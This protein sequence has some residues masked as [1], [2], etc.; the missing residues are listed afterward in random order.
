MPPFDYTAWSG[1]AAVSKNVAEQLAKSAK[2]STTTSAA[3][4]SQPSIYS[5][6]YNVAAVSKTD[7]ASTA[8][9]NHSSR[10]YQHQQQQQQFHSTFNDLYSKSNGNYRL[11]TN[12]QKFKSF[13]H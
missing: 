3:S 9:G 12:F 4:T 10:L 6:Q 11:Y 1:M 2:S 7:T 8:A 13:I 5:A